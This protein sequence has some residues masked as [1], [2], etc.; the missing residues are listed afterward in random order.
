[1]PEPDARPPGVDALRHIIVVMLENRSFDHL[2]GF[3]D[4]PDKT[5][6]GIGPNGRTN[7]CDPDDPSQGVVPA[8][9]RRS[10][11]WRVDPDHSHEAVMS[12]LRLDAAGKARNDGFVAS[13]ERKAS[14][15][16]PGPAKAARLRRRLRSVATAAVAAGAAAGVAGRRVLGGV[17]GAAGVGAWVVV[18]RMTRPDRFKGHGERIMWCWDPSRIKALATLAL[19]FGV[20]TRWYCSVPG[21]TW[22]SVV[23]RLS[24]PSWSS[25]APV[26]ALA[27]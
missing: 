9:R 14:G 26:W 8:V 15:Q 25:S 16:G 6:D 5:F 4:H 19:E 17:L 13:Y 24:T 10:L 20:C 2:L 18:G 1:M 3:L 21:E 11:R 27:Q 12:Q 22:A 7:P 23:D